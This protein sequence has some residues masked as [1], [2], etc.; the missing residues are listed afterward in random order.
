MIADY[1]LL[2]GTYPNTTAQ[3]RDCVLL[4]FTPAWTQLPSEIRGHLIRH[5]AL[6]TERERPAAAWLDR[7]LPRFDGLPRDLSL[8]RVA[9]IAFAVRD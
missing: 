6:S 1:R 2:H 3:R 9:P 5:P 8:N 4:S 7:L